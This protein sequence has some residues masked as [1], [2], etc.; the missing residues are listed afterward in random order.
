MA[1]IR[2]EGKIYYLYFRESGIQRKR[3]L[4]T[5]SRQVAERVKVQIENELAAKQFNIQY[6]SPHLQKKLPEFLEEAIEYSKVNKAPRTVE[7]E[8]I[9]Y[10]NFL[11][12]CGPI[13][14]SKVDIRL[15]EKY[16]LFLLNEKHFSSPGINI[17][18]RHQRPGTT[19]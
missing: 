8:E 1:S 12:F 13:N 11:K 2:K 17:E 7:R 3:S 4:R 14:T 19:V 16:K 10:K 5:S 6:Y 18:L 15:I 9:I